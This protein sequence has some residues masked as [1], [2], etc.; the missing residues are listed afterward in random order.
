M[1]NYILNEYEIENIENCITSIEEMFDFKFEEGEAE[2]I[3]NFDEFCNLIISKINH[4]NIES[5]TSQQAFYK[6]R[7]IIVEEKI[8]EKSKIKPKIKLSELFP[9]KNRIE[10]I[11]KV[12]QN[13]GFK[14]NILFPPKFV[15]TLTC[16]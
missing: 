6:L 11:R 10:L 1:E 14:F 4:E 2:K 9:R 15:V 16:V 3:K 12:E 13:I 5:C 8:F 7:N